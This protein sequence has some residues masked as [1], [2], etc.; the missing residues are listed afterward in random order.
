M[1]KQ[2]SVESVQP[3]RALLVGAYPHA[4]PRQIAEEQLEELQRLAETFGMEVAGT[5]ICLVRVFDAATVVKEGKLQELSSL[6]DDLMV[7]AV[8]FDEEISPAQQRNLER[9]FGKVVMDR[10]ELILEVFAQRAQ[11]KEARLQIE[12]ARTKYQAPR[13][14]RLWTHLSR[15]TGSGGGGAGGGAYLKGE[16]EKQIEIDRRLLKKRTEQL[17]QEVEDVRACRETQRTGRER[18]G[19]PVFAIVGYTNAGKSTLLNALTDADVLVEDKLF[20]T[21]DTT[22][23]RMTLRNGQEILL[24]DTVGFIRKLPHLLV[25]AFRSTLEESL[26]ADILLHVVDASQPVALEQAKTTLEVLKELGAKDK[27]VLTLLNKVDACADLQTLE[28]LRIAFPKT[29]QISATT[30][31]GFDALEELMISELASRRQLLKLKVP[32][33]EYVVVAEVMRQGHILKHDYEDNDVTLTV[34]LPIAL[35]GKLSRYIQK[36]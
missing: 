28:R 9:H 33:S 11:T 17:K 23:R 18:S 15:Q 34:E 5:Q 32:Q 30:R 2:S 1:E 22:T 7:D 16:G 25:A 10:T 14:K 19:V 35:A 8:V 36:E 27:P 6:A 26:Q 12:L 31:A 24:I 29:V 13:L 21:L 3:K 20:A 4:T